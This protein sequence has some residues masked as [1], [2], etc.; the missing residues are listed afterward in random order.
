MYKI[1]QLPED[2]VVRERLEIEFDE[3]GSYRYYL[4]RKKEH[5]TFS[6]IELVAK[7]LKLRPKFINAA[8]LKDKQAVTE[9]Y[10]SVN[11]TRA[12]KRDV[13]IWS[14]DDNDSFISLKYLGCGNER[15][16]IGTLDGNEFEIVVRNLD[17]GFIP[18]KTGYVPNYF[19][20]QRFGR[21]KDNHIIGRMIVRK[22]FKEAVEALVR[23][24]TKAIAEYLES[25]PNNHI[26]ALRAMPKRILKF[27]IVAY[28]SHLWNNCV[29][30]YIKNN[31]D[32]YKDEKFPLLG[33]DTEENDKTKSRIIES[34]LKKES[35]HP[36]EFIIRQMPE[37]TL[38]SQD[39]RIFAE[40]E[41]LK[42]G[43]PEKD[44]LNKGRY[45]TNVSFYLG[46]GSYATNVIR[47]MF[48]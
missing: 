9:Q 23:K 43:K 24:D 8:G 14:N 3:K 12:P 48:S 25:D 2:F 20:E 47:E 17:E 38:E 19:D 39:R 33:F 34:I 11:S 45:K 36:R 10:I 16:N 13:E 40:V 44:E 18:V 29:K 22:Q 42:L 46:K 7:K 28:Q 4:L 5:S 37:L 21:D 41:N 27:Y 31:N 32:V 15:I 26:G 1:K 6:A 30:D 35:L